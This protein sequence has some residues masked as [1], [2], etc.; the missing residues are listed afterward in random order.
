VVANDVTAPGIGFESPDNAATITAADG[1]TTSVGPAPKR[2]V[3]DAIL[4]RVAAL[5]AAQ[6]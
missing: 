2:V 4:D 1:T 3:A 6:R 5:L